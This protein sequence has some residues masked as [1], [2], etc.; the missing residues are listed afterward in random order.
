MIMKQP[1]AE[2]SFKLVKRDINIVVSEHMID[3]VDIQ[4]VRIILIQFLEHTLYCLM[5]LQLGWV[6]QILNFGCL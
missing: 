1:Y 6:I 2:K 3:F 4:R 5:L